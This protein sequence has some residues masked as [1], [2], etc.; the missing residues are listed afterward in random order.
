MFAPS[1]YHDAGW[2]SQQHNHQSLPYKANYRRQL[3]DE[4][5]EVAPSSDDGGDDSAWEYGLCT[6]GTPAPCQQPPK[7]MSIPRLHS[8]QKQSAPRQSRGFTNGNTG[9]MG[10]KGWGGSGSGIGGKK[11]P[12]SKANDEAGIWGW[13]CAAERDP[14]ERHFE[15]YVGHAGIP[16]ERDCGF[17]YYLGGGAEA[18]PPSPYGTG[19]NPRSFRRCERICDEDDG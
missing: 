8:L 4:P 11:H 15:T 17:P 14:L 19:I 9:A 13:L 6:S 3:L 5:V 2:R 16:D 1:N 12:V 10:A 7:G 18:P